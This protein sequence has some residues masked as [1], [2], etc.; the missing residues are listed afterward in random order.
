MLA[1]SL[2]IVFSLLTTTLIKL[3]IMDEDSINQFLKAIPETGG[4]RSRDILESIKQVNLKIDTMMEAITQISH[5]MRSMEDRLADMR[6]STREISPSSQSIPS[7]P[8]NKNEAIAKL[9]LGIMW[10]F[11]RSSHGSMTLESHYELTMPFMG[12]L[13]KMMC[14]SIGKGDVILPDVNSARGKII[15]T[16]ITSNTVSPTDVYPTFTDRDLSAL[17]GSQDTWFVRVIAQSYFDELKK[18]RFVL[19]HHISDIIA[20]MPSTISLTNPRLSTTVK[21]RPPTNL[22]RQ[23]YVPKVGVRLEMAKMMLASKDSSVSVS[24]VLKNAIS[25]VES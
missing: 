16:I 24:E 19:P 1:V 11:Y 4:S 18:I 23:I 15:T 20:A 8:K 10:A 13:V 25:T 7:K 9:L 6:V 5:R 14:D 17:E 3:V 12:K 2:V 22:E 21:S